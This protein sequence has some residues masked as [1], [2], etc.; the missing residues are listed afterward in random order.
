MCGDTPCP[1]APGA[2]VVVDVGVNLDKVK[3]EHARASAAAVAQVCH[4]QERAHSLLPHDIYT[5]IHDSE[6]VRI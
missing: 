5:Y 3:V 1:H 6:G 2:V 4:G